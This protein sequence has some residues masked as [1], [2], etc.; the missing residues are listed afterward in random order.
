[1]ACGLCTAKNLG[2]TRGKVFYST[3]G[4][5]RERGHALL[6]ISVLTLCSFY[7]CS[8][9]FAIHLHLIHIT[10]LPCFDFSSHSQAILY[11]YV[12]YEQSRRLS[13]SF[14]THKKKM[15]IPLFKSSLPSISGCES[16]YYKSYSVPIYTFIPH[17]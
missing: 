11:T 1:M 12:F 6:L 7:P 9:S 17:R 10:T 8:I 13:I 14:I 5:A 2:A 3:L 16:I 4:L 15:I